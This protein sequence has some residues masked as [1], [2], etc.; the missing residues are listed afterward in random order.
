[1]AAR[2][3]GIVAPALAVTRGC[4]CASQRGR[5]PWL[6]K[7]ALNS[8]SRSPS[9]VSEHRFPDTVALAGTLNTHAHNH[10]AMCAPEKKKQKGKQE[11]PGGRSCSSSSA[12]KHGSFRRAVYVCRGFSLPFFPP[13][14]FKAVC[15]ETDD[16]R[17]VRP[18]RGVAAVTWATALP[19]L[20]RM[21]RS[22]II[23]PVQ[24]FFTSRHWGGEPLG[25]SWLP[26]GARRDARLPARR[27]LM[28]AQEHHRP[29]S[30]E[31]MQRSLGLAQSHTD[32]AS[33]FPPRLHLSFSSFWNAPPSTCQMSDRH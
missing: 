26:T 14:C 32:W 13:F 2:T 29:F 24:F 31:I 10:G 16:A 22:L 7:E 8:L 1:M 18:M 17:R 28:G 12:N 30:L 6:L 15:A 33:T 9:S 5:T 3:T 23:P 4:L 25:S 27:L 19:G 21:D 11:Q 20:T